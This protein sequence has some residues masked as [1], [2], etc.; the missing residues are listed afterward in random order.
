[1]SNRLR[2]KTPS[3]RLFFRDCRLEAGFPQFPCTLL[4]MQYGIGE[5]SCGQ[6]LKKG[7][8]GGNKVKERGKGKKGGKGGKVGKWGG[9]MKP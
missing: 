2:N 8:S 3:G 9:D 6:I 5:N 1:M 4:P 7:T